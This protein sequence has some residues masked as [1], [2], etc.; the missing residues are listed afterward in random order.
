MSGV[1][2]SQRKVPQTGMLRGDRLATAAGEG[3]R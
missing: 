2:M 3:E 1:V